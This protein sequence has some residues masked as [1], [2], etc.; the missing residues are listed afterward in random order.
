MCVD[1]LCVVIQISVL[2]KNTYLN[3]TDLFAIYWEQ[4]MKYDIQRKHAMLTKQ[5]NKQTHKQRK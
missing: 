5:I 4:F 1:Q 2:I 3:L